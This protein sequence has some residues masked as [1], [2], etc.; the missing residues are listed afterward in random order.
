MAYLVLARK[1]RPQRFEDTVGQE[2]IVQTLKNAVAQGKVSHAYL[3]CGPRG[4][5][6]T[7][8]A[9]ILS[10]ALNC[11]Q[12]QDCE[13][14]CDCE[15][16]REVARGEDL[17]VIEI[18]GAS[19]RKVEEIEKIRDNVKFRPARS[20]Y[21]IYIVDEVH[22]LST[23]AFNALLKTLEEPPEHVKFIFAT[24]EPHKVPDT[25]QSRCQ[26]MPFT[27]IRADH[28]RARLDK[29]CQLEGFQVEPNALAR[30]AQQSL[31]GMRDALSLLDRLVAS[32]SAEITEDS[33]SRALGTI[34]RAHL[35]DMLRA[36]CQRDERAVLEQIHAFDRSGGDYEELL[37]DL[38]RTGRA[39]L[40]L[41]LLG[42]TAPALAELGI[43]AAQLAPLREVSS[44]GWLYVLE[45]L[46][47]AGAN[48]KNS[49]DERVSVELLL[50]RLARVGD[51]AS[52]PVWLERLGQLEDLLE[53]KGL[54]ELP[55]LDAAERAQAVPRAAAVPLP[56][57][58]PAAAQPTAEPMLPEPRP[59][60]QP[61]PA[62]EA[63]QPHAAPRAKPARQAAIQP[64][65]GQDAAKTE[66]RRLNVDAIQRDWSRVL[67]ALR[68]KK[69]LGLV[70]LMAKSRPASWANGV[71]RVLI[72]KLSS[73][74]GDHLRS[75]ESALNQCLSEIFG[76]SM[77][78]AFDEGAVDKPKSRNPVEELRQ[79]PLVRE[80]LEKFQGQII[81]PR[82]N[83][84]K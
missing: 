53:D 46:D 37:A 65:A 61:Q 45:S 38:M 23:A 52:V 44:D 51:L 60:P 12:A 1:Y 70:S 4:V 55:A 31:G 43:D 36:V 77:R 11:P 67:D 28:I 56:V 72:P 15:V 76:L 78:C 73:F 57:P 32:G 6:K 13:P 10:K 69:Q 17:D 16:C 47:E 29:I 40:H 14:C 82:K 48:L 21:K 62:R 2:S 30:V 79:N 41:A 71:L 81:P 54:R 3:F 59:E 25:I 26:V 8:M 80:V 33:V 22:M 7:S 75:S 34:S 68:A 18:D 5:G 50:L 19:N 84:R 66:W 42:P 24:T 58:L 20:R 64:A 83:R 9:R 27:K 39:A 35:V 63:P 74:E 49:L